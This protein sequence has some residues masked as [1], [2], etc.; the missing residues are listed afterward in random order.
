MASVGLCPRMLLGMRSYKIGT[1]D[2]ITYFSTLN[3]SLEQ[4]FRFIYY[5]VHQQRFSAKERKDIIVVFNSWAAKQPT[6]KC[7]PTQ[8]S[9]K[10]NRT[11]GLLP[12]IPSPTYLP[13]HLH[14]S[15]KRFQPETPGTGR[16]KCLQE[17]HVPYSFR[18]LQ[19][20][21]IDANGIFVGRRIL[22]L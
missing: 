9:Q 15:C 18:T 3:F 16:G 10:N 8:G 17:C 19:R 7:H 20:H 14:T 2:L 11:A 6:L 22:P 13:V 5:A 21:L 1:Q 4:D 12:F